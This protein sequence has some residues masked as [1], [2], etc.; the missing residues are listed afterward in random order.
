MATGTTFSKP[1]IGVRAVPVRTQR[2][3]VV[4]FREVSV[5]TAHKVAHK[6]VEMAARK[7]GCVFEKIGGRDA[8]I[9]AVDRFYDKVI[10][11]DRVNHF[12]KNTDV[13][14]QRSK[15]VRRVWLVAKIMGQSYHQ[16]HPC[17]T[18]LH[19]TRHHA[20]MH[21]H[22]LSNSISSLIR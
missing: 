15:Q 6:D 3:L 11:D 5:E 9:T 7:G 21:A 19:A 10:A 13:K 12:F 4:R 20:H 8:M 18:S 1:P 2:R 16:V 17:S 14:K 22:C